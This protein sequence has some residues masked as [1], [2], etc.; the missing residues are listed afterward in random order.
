[1][2]FSTRRASRLVFPNRGEISNRFEI[3][4]AT[5][6]NPCKQ[7]AENKQNTKGSKWGFKSMWNLNRCDIST[8][9]ETSMYSIRAVSPS[10]FDAVT[11]LGVAISVSLRLYP[12]LWMWGRRSYLSETSHVKC[13]NVCAF[14]NK[15]SS[16]SSLVGHIPLLFTTYLQHC[17]SRYR[18]KVAGRPPIVA[19]Y[20]ASY[21]PGPR[22][23]GNTTTTSSSSPRRCLPVSF[24]SV[25]MNKNV[26]D[27][28]TQRLSAILN[29]LTNDR[30]FDQLAPV[31]F[32]LNLFGRRLNQ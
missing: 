25:M 19:K 16:W 13:V 7:N 5:S 9:V 20:T 4:R 2:R 21:R 12:D 23:L 27:S 28:S 32:W 1:M 30:D 10:L 29:G 8:R 14:S 17:P 24:L 6:Q 26:V 31:T 18:S 22:R 11:A 3:R 15:S